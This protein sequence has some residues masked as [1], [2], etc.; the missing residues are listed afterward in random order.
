MKAI[1]Q[2][3]VSIV[4]P[5]YNEEE[6]L[7]E[8]IESILGQTYQ[9]WE[10]TIVNNCSTDRSPDIAARYAAKDRRIRVHNNESFLEMLANHNVAV[11]QISSES[12]YCKVVLADDWIFP[13]CLERMVALAE[14]YPSV[15]VVSA[16]ER[17]GDQVRL[18]GLPADCTRVDGREASRQFLL[19]T[20]V[21][22]GSQNSVMYRADLVRNR[23]PFYD[24]S[25]CYADFESCFALLRTSDLGFVHKILTF[26]RPRPQSINA[27]S[28]DIGTH[29]GSMLGLLSTYG[30]GCL[31]GDEFAKCLD[32]HLGLYYRFLGRRLWV[33]RNRAFWSYHKRVLTGA[34]LELDRTRLVKTAL[35]QLCSS[36]IR[37]A[38]GLE[39]LKRA[40]SLRRIRNSDTRRIVLDTR[41]GSGVRIGRPDNCDLTVR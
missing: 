10:C 38:A 15:G 7:G 5:M 41:A 25:D 13:D 21:L 18:T 8:C 27:I 2:P 3:L 35:A 14:E 17:C 33:E 29:F 20:L 11:S 30:K 40:L 6:H 32:R 24:E 36:L 9:N 28:A 19:G 4:T 31:P 1:S 12:K 23:R 22:F 16:Y 26:S 37:P 39:S 34:G